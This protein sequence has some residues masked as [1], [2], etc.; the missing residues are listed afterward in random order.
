MTNLAAIIQRI[1]QQELAHQRSSE[2]GVVTE[3]FPHTTADDNHNYEASVR[4]KHDGLDLPK[5]AIA[6]N[7]LGV[8]TPPNVG[9]LVLVQFING[10]LNQPVITGRFYHSDAAPP[11]HTADDLLWEQRV[12]NDNT[13]NHLR[14]TADGTIWLQRDVTKPEDNSEAKTSLKID[15]ATGDIELKSGAVTV[16]ITH[17]QSIV[18][19]DKSGNSIEMSDAA[20]TLTSKVPFKIDASGQSLEIKANTIDF[21]KG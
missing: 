6:V 12:A 17:D 18:I 2:L 14:F 11:L 20:F 16:A 15:G 3:L 21:N 7:H 8:A 4:L 13:L 10:D 5:V 9:D 1:V 19:T